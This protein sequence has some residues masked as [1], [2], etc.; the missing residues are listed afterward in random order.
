MSLFEQYASSILPVCALLLILGWAI[1]IYLFIANRSKQ[2][3]ISTLENHIIELNQSISTHASQASF[4]QQLLQRNLSD[5]NQLNTKI[6]SLQ[7]ETDSLRHAQSQ[8]KIQLSA[9]H[10]KN[11]NL[12]N[13]NQSALKRE[14]LLSD[15][16]L[17][18]QEKYQTT[19]TQFT[20]LQTILTEKENNF[21][22]QK[23]QFLET[24]SQLTLEFEQIAHKIFTQK[25]QDF[26]QSSQQSLNHLLQPFK[27]QI[28]GFQ[29]RINEVHDQTIKGHTALDLEIKKILDI[30]LQMS[31]EADTLSKALKGDKKLSGNWGEF[32]LEKTLQMAGLMK[33]EHYQSQA[34]YK[35][36]TGKNQYPDFV[37]HLPDNKQM[38]L[39]SKV[40]LVAYDQAISADTRELINLSMQSHIKAIKNHI[41]DLSKKDYDKL[42]EINSPSF[43]LMFMPI[44]PAYIEAMKF[45][46]S[47]FSYGY[48]KNVILVSH[49][50]LM[51]ILRTVAN[52]WMMQK[53]NQEAK[54]ISERAADIYNNVCLISERLNKV[55]QN[56]GT[57][58]HNFNDT[59][60]AVSGKQGLIGKVEKFT[61]LSSKANKSMS[62][63][64]PINLDIDKVELA[65]DE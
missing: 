50:T 25:N 34:H 32:Q 14:Q 26:N 23:Q 3:H 47:L 8:L 22:E 37:I 46:S 48:Q 18:L 35:T 28:D 44:E 5:I 6:Q 42:P 31:A 9:L 56:I 29:K 7:Q 57:L 45:D 27:E 20:E 65:I 59:I 2:T 54:M 41:D 63:I 30:G 24:K 62:E 1:C 53:G 38:I 49:T 12:E 60:K 33:D 36:S 4:D 10:T 40:S 21:A 64:K 51:P 15:R 16:L 55:G 58:S 11:I 13:T 39:D 52:L 19:H 61:Q 43:V 17:A